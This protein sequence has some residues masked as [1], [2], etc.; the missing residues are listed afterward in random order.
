MIQHLLDIFYSINFTGIATYIL[1]LKLDSIIIIASTIA[2][3]WMIAYSM[4]RFLKHALRKVLPKKRYKNISQKNKNNKKQS[5]KEEKTRDQ[6][7]I[8]KK[9]KMFLSPEFIKEVDLS[10]TDSLPGL[11]NLSEAI[12]RERQVAQENPR[13][14]KIVIVDARG[15]PI[16]QLND[17]AVVKG[18]EVQPRIP[19]EMNLRPEVIR[20][21]PQPLVISMPD[22]IR[23]GLR[24]TVISDGILPLLNRMINPDMRVPFMPNMPNPPQRSEV[25][26]HPLLNVLREHVAQH[27]VVIEVKVE[28]GQHRHNHAHAHPHQEHAQP[29]QN[30]QYI[31]QAARDTYSMAIS[32]PTIFVNRAGNIM[33]STT[34]VL[35]SMKGS[36]MNFVYRQETAE[37]KPTGV[38]RVV[39]QMS[40]QMDMNQ[41]GPAIEGGGRGK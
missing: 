32:V 36:I 30:A 22:I 2:L 28:T 10:K 33:L 7:K 13:L 40:V 18:Q 9:L 8:L 37:I 31:S 17:I 15:R 27:R 1:N 16:A 26:M 23:A 5:E 35:C 25:P 12:L 41:N 11:P 4:M 38:E 20:P 24:P 3:L 21:L 39:Q 34:T 19:Q 6:E 29:R 14:E